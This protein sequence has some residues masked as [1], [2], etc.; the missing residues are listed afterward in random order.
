MFKH[1][2]ASTDGSRLSDRAVNCAIALAK[3][4]GAR[5]TVYH[6]TNIFPA[7]PYPEYEAVLNSVRADEWDAAQ[8]AHA[9]RILEK[10]RARAAKAGI[11]CVVRSAAAVQPS[12]GILEQAKKAR[13]DLIV[14]AS[15]G[16]RGLQK[17]L[18]G[19]ETSK[20]LAHGKLPVLVVR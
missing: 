6:A 8:A 9:R 20:V 5:L 1:I 7:T 16:R 13:C 2:L 11:N 18:L 17:L 19:S 15:H 10:C 14:M 4:T 12:D 3:S